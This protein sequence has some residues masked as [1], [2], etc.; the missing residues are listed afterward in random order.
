MCVMSQKL[1]T[2]EIVNTAARSTMLPV[3]LGAEF[4]LLCLVTVMTERVPYKLSFEF[5]R[6]LLHVD[7]HSNV[8]IKK[9]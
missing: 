3:S 5:S 1:I 7:T 6:R 9:S 8:I 2:H 4:K